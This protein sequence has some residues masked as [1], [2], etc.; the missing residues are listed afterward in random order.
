MLPRTGWHLS[1]LTIDANARFFASR[2]QVPT[3]ALTMGVGKIM[4]AKKIQMLVWYKNKKEVARA[5]L[6]TKV[7]TTIPATM[8]LMHP[9]ATILADKNRTLSR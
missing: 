3:H 6:D 9:D 5:M 4:Q 7:Y 2:D 8:L 1:G